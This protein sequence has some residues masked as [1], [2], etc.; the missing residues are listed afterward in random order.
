MVTVVTHLLPYR[1][2][3]AM[4]GAM[5]RPDILYAALV[6]DAGVEHVFVP[7]GRTYAVFEVAAF[8]F[9]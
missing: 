4:D 7:S 1:L 3:F 6:V 8:C 5:M 9:K 2:A